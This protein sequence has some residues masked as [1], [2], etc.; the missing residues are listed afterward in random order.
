MVCD[1]LAAEGQPPGLA[2]LA[3]ECADRRVPFFL[4]F[5]PLTVALRVPNASTSFTRPVLDVDYGGLQQAT[6]RWKLRNSTSGA[7]LAEETAVGGRVQLPAQD[8]GLY[9]AEVG[10]DV[11]GALLTPTWISE[12]FVLDPRPPT[13]LFRDV[14]LAESSVADTYATVNV[15][16]AD[17][18][19]LQYTLCPGGCPPG[20]DQS[21][22]DVCSWCRGNC[23]TDVLFF[24]TAEY[25]LPL[26]PSALLL[27]HCLGCL[28]ET[29]HWG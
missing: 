5:K 15:F 20:D 26:R 24:L 19:K 16:D 11:A 13:L 18:T 1:A 23:A 3:V 22:E 25:C 29:T 17:F 4:E 14:P 27:C 21:W 7:V 10:Y 8:S 12:P 2:L 28:A 6:L 9:A